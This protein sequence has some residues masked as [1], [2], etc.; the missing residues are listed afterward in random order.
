VAL[1][2]QYPRAAAAVAGVLLAAGLVVLY[3]AAKL[4]RRG[5]R[6]WKGRR[7]PQVA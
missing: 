7:S 3:F 1:A 2:V 6:R 5:W 4:I